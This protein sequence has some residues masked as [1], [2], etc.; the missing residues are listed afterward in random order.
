MRP[1]R[2]ETVESAVAAMAY[3][4]D[5]VAARI[6][7]VDDFLSAECDAVMAQEGATIRL[8]QLCRIRTQVRAILQPD[9]P[10]EV[11]K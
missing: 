6:T 2:G 10:V 9:E 4:A 1:M 8:E 3:Y 7:A 5:D 11:P